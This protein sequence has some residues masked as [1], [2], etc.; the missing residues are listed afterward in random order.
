MRH[1][2]IDG[3][4]AVLLFAGALL[5]ATPAQG[6]SGEDEIMK[7]VPYGAGNWDRKLGNHRAVVRVPDKADAVR[8][9]LPW[10]R[11]DRD[12]QKKQVLVA[13][14]GGALIPNVR[15][16]SITADAG[17]VVFQPAAGP[18]DYCVYY[19]PY[20]QG[21]G[22][23]S[24]GGYAAIEAAAEADWLA[25]SGLDG[26][27]APGTLPAAE[28]VEFQAR[29]DFH[30]FDPM[31]LPATQAETGALV[32]QHPGKACLIFPEDR[33]N[34]VRMFDALP[35]C[36]LDRGP[37]NAFAGEALRNE[38]YVFQL[39]C[40]A[41]SQ[42]LENLGIAF[43][44]LRTAAGGVLPASA[45][46]CFNLGGVDWLGRSFEKAVDVPKGRVQALWIGV[47]IPHA[48]AP[49]RYEGALRI[50]FAN[51]ETVEVAL[52]LTVQEGVVED[53]GDG[54]LWKHARLRWLDST[55][56]LDDEVAAPF[57][58][59]EVDGQTV[60]CLGREVRLG[61][62]GLPA[63]VVSEFSASV[64]A[65]QDEGREI[66]AG[67]MDFVVEAEEGPVVWTEGAPRFT[68]TEPGVVEWE[69]A[70][71]GKGLAL[72]C[73]ARMEPDGCATF[74]LTL[75]AKEAAR[76]KDARLE[77]PLR[78]E[79][80]RYMM[81]MGRRGGFR[82][83]AW[84]WTWDQK[85]HQDSVWLGDVNAGLQC[86]LMGTEYERPLV[87]VYYHYKPLL[88]PECWHNGGKGGCA[89]EETG[90]A[91]MLR[92]FSG[93]RALAAGEEI[94]FVFRLLITPFKTLDPGHWEQ[95]YFHR[96]APV[97]KAKE[98]GARIINIHHATPINH[99]INYPFV[100]AEVLSDYVAQ[101][102][103]QDM[104]VKI[105]YTV[106][107]LTN[108]VTELWALRSLADEVLIDGPG[109]G[110][111]WL[112]E[113]LVSNY[114]RAWEADVGEGQVCAAIITSGMSRWHNYYLE[115]LRWL[116]EEVEID[117]IYI[118]DVSYDREVMKRA[119]KILDRTRPGSLI[120]VH[121]WNHFNNRAGFAVCAN[122]YLE[123]FPY[124]NSIW[125]G[126]GH[127]YN[128]S[129]DH[130]LVELSGIPFG[131]YGEMLQGGGNPW[132][133]MV[134]GMSRRHYHDHDPT[135]V[136]EMWDAFGIEDARM[137]SYW[138]PACPVRTGRDDV[139][140]TVYQREGKSL[141]AL[142]SWAKEPADVVLEIDWAA[143]GLDSNKAAIHAPA[144]RDFQ[145]EKRF[146][147]GA[148]IPVAPGRGWMLVLEAE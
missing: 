33:A 96:Y 17:E 43:G 26:Q 7:R 111:S 117:G 57:T 15:V 40:Y 45:L 141:V 135:P 55:L 120:D 10:R 89:I 77:I 147:P 65:V 3:F 109:G 61:A 148:A 71:R 79:A 124:I 20:A 11:R 46:R 9:R 14:P 115:G 91:V 131:L 74:T 27:E 121:S 128:A 70:S 145:E 137:I 63:S 103:G 93:A 6:E 56:A 31:E 1:V 47:D 134:Y 38:Y 37:A 110:Y 123:N 35:L 53:R 44:D 16:F 106:R 36:W 64:D 2:G 72:D 28:V 50:T 139:L 29:S 78:P 86:K 104:K 138:D 42:D 116:L 127:D 66:L 32:A 119:R 22:G 84:D 97:A 24:S 5:A 73:Q 81:G 102:H 90:H 48:A 132:R 88:L 60:R 76:L 92:A 80:A 58:P 113:H 21:A 75:K 30:R 126:E 82:P 114:I 94:V 62:T 54:E 144:V 67:A 142:A 19:L 136:W 118:D 108:H 23:I 83:D 12:P 25:R 69:S 8:V 140:A 146:A 34:P 18:G 133:G 112:Q 51:A 125:F 41:A 49:G 101:A 68:R 107:E 99:F 39:G 87:N 98:V 100:D 52:A 130:W 85:K 4:F 59:L 105:Y 122:L 13:D 143:L 129:P 95:R